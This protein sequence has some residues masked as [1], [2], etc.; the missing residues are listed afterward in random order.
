[1]TPLSDRL[2]VHR[3]RVCRSLHE[4]QR[5]TSVMRHG[6]SRRRRLA[7]VRRHVHAGFGHVAMQLA[8]AHPGQLIVCPN[9]WTLRWFPESGVH[10]VNVPE[11]EA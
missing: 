2:L 5:T 6:R 1:V 10:E 8:H 7:R 3:L 4:L 9:G 11:V